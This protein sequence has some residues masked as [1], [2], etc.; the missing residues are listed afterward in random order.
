[1]HFKPECVNDFMDL[2]KDAYP[3]ITAM[4]GCQSLQLLNDIHSPE[5]L[6][7]YS[8]WEDDAALQNYRYSELFTTTWA[9]T[10]VLF[11]QKAEAWSVE[12]ITNY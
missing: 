12:T 1:M 5:I 2:F 11:A 6:F 10:K 3:K 7:T 8:T 4:P 9:K